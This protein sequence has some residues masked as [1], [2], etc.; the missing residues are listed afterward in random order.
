MVTEAIEYAVAQ[1]RQKGIT[2]LLSEWEGQAVVVIAAWELPPGWS[3][4]TT[5]LLLKLPPSFPSGKPD[6]FWV[7]PD[8]VLGAGRTPQNADVIETIGGEQWRRF[9]WHPSSWTPCA[10]PLWAY[11]EF[12]M[13]RLRQ[14]R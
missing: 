14:A 12:V 1:L 5:R 10:D 6:M 3:K 2:A 4:K 8:V 7:Q 9:S 11:L 13:G